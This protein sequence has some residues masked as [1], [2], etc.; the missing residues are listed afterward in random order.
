MDVNARCGTARPFIVPEI[1]ALPD[2]I[3]VTNAQ[4]VADTLRAAFGPGVAVVIADMTRTV[5][6][7]SSAVR[8]LLLASKRAAEANAELRLV[9]EAAAVLRVLRIVGIDRL[10]N[11]Y[12]SLEAAL[13]N[14]PQA[15]AQEAD[16][17]DGQGS[18][19]SRPVTEA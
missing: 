10:L 17:V 4:S 9:I 2:E 1:V 14:A 6:C 16:R 13:T 5:F 15:Q 18:L 8:C 3:D 12:P 7:D 11:I 19:V